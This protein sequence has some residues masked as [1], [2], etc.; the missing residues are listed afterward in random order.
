MKFLAYYTCFFGGTNNYSCLIP[1][2]PSETYDCYYFTNNQS[3]YDSLNNTK[4]IRIFMN[5]I[6]IY[7]DYILDTMSSKEIRSCPHHFEILNNYDYLCWFDTKLKVFES[8]V[9][10]AISKMTEL[11][12]IIAMT[13]H[14]YSDKYNNVWDEYNT[15]IQHDKYYKQKDL[16]SSYIKKQ[17]QSGFSEKINV[18]YCGGFSIRKNNKIVREFNEFWFTNIKECGIE[19]QISLQF[20]QQ[21]FDNCILGL[22]YCE[23]WKYFY[24]PSFTFNKTN[25]FCI[26]LLS[27]EERWNKM[28]RRFKNTGLD[29]SRWMAA[30]PDN[31]LIYD[32]F[33]DS[34]TPFQKACTQSHLHAWKHLANSTELE[35]ALILEDDACFDVNWKQK[36]QQFFTDINDPEWDMI[37][38]NAS[39]SIE[40]RDKWVKVTEQYLC[41]GYILSKKGAR[42][43]LSMFENNCAMSDWM[44][45]RLQLQGHSYSYFPWLIIK[46]GKETTIGSNIDADH[47]KVLRCLSEINYD[48]KNYEV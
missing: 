19:D 7:N 34:L 25:T 31:R 32:D 10:N 18:F 17:L 30:T 12:K 23:N 20:V 1:P 21:K 14:P 15:A 47:Q 3:I 33:L 16:Y 4:W 46:E 6:P 37:L 39:E 48:I 44:T 43:M 13:K 5:E 29:S 9:H 2:L 22:K 8:T 11:N 24:E 38:L 27:N 40:P 42:I 28:E 26:S 41:G 36:L 45:T 35:Y